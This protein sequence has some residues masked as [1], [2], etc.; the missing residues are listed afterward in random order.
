MSLKATIDADVKQA[1]RA[2]DAQTL[3]TVRLLMA[4][5]KQREVDDKI[6]L[7]DAQIMAII[8]KMLKQRRDSIAQFTQGGRV[9][10]ADKEGAEISVLQRYLPMPLSASEITE[11]I[12]SILASLAPT[13]LADLGKL[14]A[15]LKP[16]FAG[17]ADMSVVSVEAKNMLNAY[18]QKAV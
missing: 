11:K 3:G 10:L 12:S 5:I 16:I 1:M 13:S 18:L 17:R 15:Q 7:D 6:V 2:R 9:D 8:D 4:A 14:M